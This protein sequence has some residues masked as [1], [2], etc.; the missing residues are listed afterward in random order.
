MKASSVKLSPLP[1][2]PPQSR[3]DGGAVD[4]Y[5]DIVGHEVDMAVALYRAAVNVGCAPADQVVVAERDMRGAEP[6]LVFHMADRPGVRVGPEA[7][8][9]QQPCIVVRG[10]EHCLKAPGR[11]TAGEGDQP[12]LG[13]LQPDRVFEQA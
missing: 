13:E 7:E 10:I 3:Q 11:R 12:P 9:G 1:S 8:L 4:L 5:A 6:E 2:P